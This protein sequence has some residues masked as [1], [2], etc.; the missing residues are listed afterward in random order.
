[1]GFPTGGT[2]GPDRTVEF[3]LVRADVS[4]LRTA[5]RAA[6]RGAILLSGVV[7]IALPVLL[8]RWGPFFLLITVV[9]VAGLGCAW[10]RYICVS[11]DCAARARD[12]EQLEHSQTLKRT[13]RMSPSPTT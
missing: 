4:D 2:S 5:A 1:M 10:G 6:L 13:C 8:G 11:L 9:W 3:A 7:V 12:L